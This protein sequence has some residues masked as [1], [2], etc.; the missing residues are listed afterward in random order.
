MTAL[1]TWWS[2]KDFRSSLGR[3]TGR[4]QLLPAVLLALAAGLGVAVAAYGFLRWITPVDVSK[5]AAEIDV[6]RIALTVVGGV[7]GVVA[8]VIAYR[9]QRDLEQSRFIER[10]GAAAA[11]LGAPDVAVRI[12]GVYAMAGVA[13][14]SEGLR[15][16]QCIDVLCGYLRLPYDTEHGASG[17][18][19]FVVKAPRIEHGR[20]R[21]ETE[22]HIEYR[23]N[24]RE[25]R[26]T[27]LRVIANH[28]RPPA[29]YDWSANDFDFRN[30][31]L[32]GV[33]FSNATFRAL[34]SSAA[35]PSSAS[36]SS[37]TRPSP[38]KPSSVVRPS[39]AVHGSRMR[40]SGAVPGST[41]RLSPAT[42]SSE[43]RP[44]PAPPSSERRPSPAKSGSTM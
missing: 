36:L 4:I 17:R 42:L 7:G 5:T 24:D 11:Q 41:M 21:G 35:R 12:A 43:R 37:A 31:Y 40:P 22:E 8:L 38:A 9:R 19:K 39:P 6:T 3:R 28:L 25:V 30:A 1:R 34:Q 18:T 15:R 33:D 32:E 14:E 13:D 16:Q 23:Q 20:V 26:A 27:I 2:I 29:E 10:F 44:S